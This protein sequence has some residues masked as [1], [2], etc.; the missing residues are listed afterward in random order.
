[1]YFLS[2]QVFVW[3]AYSAAYMCCSVSYAY[4]IRL[5]KLDIFSSLL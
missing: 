3:S 5:P 2:F 4:I 1:M